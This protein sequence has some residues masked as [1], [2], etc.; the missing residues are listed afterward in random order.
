[1]AATTTKLQDLA[2]KVRFFSTLHD[3]VDRASRNDK[4]RGATDLLAALPPTTPNWI[5]DKFTIA[6]EQY[7][8][9]VYEPLKE[10]L[11]CYAKFKQFAETERKSSRVNVTREEVANLSS[12]VD[13]A[14]SDLSKYEDKFIDEK[15][16]TSS[17]SSSSSSSDIFRRSSSSSDETTR[18]GSMVKKRLSEIERRI[19]DRLD[20]DKRLNVDEI[21]AV[22]RK[23]SAD[24]SSLDS[25][26]SQGTH[27][28]PVNMYTGSLPNLA[29]VLDTVLSVLD[30]AS[31]SDQF[32]SN[33]TSPDDFLKYQESKPSWLVDGA[34]MK[35]INPFETLVSITAMY[36]RLGQPMLGAI[37]A[38][39][40]VV[41]ALQKSA[42]L[43]TKDEAR[44]LN[45]Q[46][47]MD[48]L[49]DLSAQLLMA[50]MSGKKAKQLDEFGLA[51]Q[52]SILQSGEKVSLKPRQPAAS[53]SSINKISG[54]DQPS[55]SGGPGSSATGFMYRRLDKQRLNAYVTQLESFKK[56][57]DSERLLDH[58]SNLSERLSKRMTELEAQ[59]DA[60][61]KDAD[62]TRSDFL[63]RT[64]SDAK[65]LA[66]TG[67]CRSARRTIG[68]Y[69]AMHVGFLVKKHR[70]AI[71][72][73]NYWHAM[74]D[75]GIMTDEDAM[76]DIKRYQDTRKEIVVTAKAKLNEE[77]TA[78]VRAALETS[79]G[80]K[81]TNA[82]IGLSEKQGTEVDEAFTRLLVW[83]GDQ[84]DRVADLYARGAPTLVQSLLDPQFLT[85]YALKLLRL[86]GAWL[87]LRIAGRVFQGMYD[88]RVYSRDEQPPQPIV[89]VGMFVGIDVALNLVL[90]TA[91][92]FAKYLFK[93]VDNQFPVD[94]HLL[95][96]WGFDYLVSTV[97]VVV[98]AIIIGQII[99]RKK[100]FRYK[101]EGD[102]G[103]RA[104]QQMVMY[105]YCIMLFVPFFRLANG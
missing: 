64:L 10:F 26:L 59:L 90:A 69:V 15:I 93:T 30:A 57:V 77:A 97:V 8:S 71:E 85:I 27:N 102:R 68:G 5:T 32:D 18:V 41:A 51:M 34:V 13:K 72:Y 6:L 52:S 76:K 35:Q 24:I 47:V 101:Y 74:A 54:N 62:P 84:A 65:T 89:F 99:R 63:K 2:Y 92:V 95:S 11:Q 36:D 39:I 81:A 38:G 12:L 28:D 70:D 21:R 78:K 75:A 80:S 37:D 50:P 79:A 44:K 86:M 16:K 42:M 56:A 17:S 98:I 73:I 82:H 103:I 43:D 20:K 94:G 40:Q 58:L 105:I 87:A 7:R 96:L 23:L 19:G 9:D 100:Y 83:I 33:K 60:A 29:K 1:M 67:F 25:S 45:L 4:V 31:Q 66:M 3:V 88:D 48:M 14:I 104:M 61:V 46:K 55:S 91:L 53:S 49:T 22:I